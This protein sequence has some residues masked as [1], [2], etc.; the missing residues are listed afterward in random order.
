MHS[1]APLPSPSPSSLWLCWPL[2]TPWRLQSHGVVRLPGPWCA[3]RVSRQCHQRGRA[4]GHPRGGRGGGAGAGGGRARGRG[5][6]GGGGGQGPLVQVPASGG[7]GSLRTAFR[8]ADSRP[9][10]AGLPSE[11][12]P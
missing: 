8:P 3:G 5:G 6:G 10:P 1:A 7:R 4:Q 2:E 9:G 11:P 12:Q